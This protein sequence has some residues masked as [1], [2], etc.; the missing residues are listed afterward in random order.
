[1]IIKE[2]T[3]EI[4]VSRALELF[5]SSSSTTGAHQTAAMHK[6]NK[7]GKSIII[8]CSRAEFTVAQTKLCSLNKWKI[9]GSAR[10]ITQDHPLLCRQHKG[11]AH[12]D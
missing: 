5:F 7:R 1:V 4:P 9:D 3:V 10:S 6:A 8:T 11:S 12:T 2:Q